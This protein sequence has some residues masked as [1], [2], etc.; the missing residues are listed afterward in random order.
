M[1]DPGGLRSRCGDDGPHGNGGEHQADSAGAERVHPPAMDTRGGCRVA[2]RGYQRARVESPARR[3]VRLFFQCAAVATAP[4]PRLSPLNEP[5]ARAELEHP[6]AADGEG[7]SASRTAVRSRDQARADKAA[8]RGHP[9]S[10]RAAAER[11]CHGTARILD[12]A[13]ASGRTNRSTG[14]GGAART[15]GTSFSRPSSGGC[16]ASPATG[17]GTR[18]STITGRRGNPVNCSPT[19]A[20]VPEGSSRKVHRRVQLRRWIDINL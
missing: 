20:D 5:R 9:R 16:C 12:P 15:A 2:A 6:A 8:D 19:F 3:E 4:A 7:S 10:A 11:R 13:T 1:P 14:R 17:A 18:G